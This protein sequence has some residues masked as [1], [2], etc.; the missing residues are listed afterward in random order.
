MHKARLIEY[1][2]AAG[3]VALLPPGVDAAEALIRELGN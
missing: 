3:T 1:D 2:E